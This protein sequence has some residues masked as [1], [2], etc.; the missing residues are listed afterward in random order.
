MQTLRQQGLSVKVIISSPVTLIKGGSSG[1]LRKSAVEST[2]L[3]QQFCVNQAL[4]Q[5]EAETCHSLCLRSLWLKTL[6]ILLNN[7]N[8]NA[9]EYRTTYLQNLHRTQTATNLLQKAGS[10]FYNINSCRYNTPNYQWMT[11]C[12]INVNKKLSCCTETA[13]RF[14]SL[15]ILLS[16]SS[17]LKVTRNDTVE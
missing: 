7:K 16:H 14:L 13:R 2:A 15:N 12:Y 3:A 17:S 11:R 4:K 5:W 10:S 1:L 6:V 8:V 9:L